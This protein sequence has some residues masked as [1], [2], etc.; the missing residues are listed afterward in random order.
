MHIAKTILLLMTGVV[1][2]VALMVSCGDEQPTAQADAPTP[3]A[4][5][6]A[7]DAAVP[8]CNCPAAEPPLT[9]N[10]FI[11]KMKDV[12]IQPNQ[13]F[14]FGVPC[15]LNTDLL[16]GGCVTDIPWNSTLL[17]S[18]FYGLQ[19]TGWLCSFRNETAMEVRVYAYV[20]CLARAP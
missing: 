2:G 8:S 14:S 9:T 12:V 20:R 4:D 6:V 17:D 13:S 3:M 15:P 10:R 11:T 7:A 18:G 16:S 5:A 19:P 1:G